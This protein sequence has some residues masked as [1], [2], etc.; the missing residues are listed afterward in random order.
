[1]IEIEGKF[2]D[3]DIKE[4]RK[5]L[6]LNNAKKIHKMMLYKRYVFFLLTGEKGYIRTRQENKLVTITMKTYPKDS[7]FAK[8]TEIS[9]N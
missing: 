7:K 8:E 6:K 5:N 4:L 2:L 9:V 1:M 3:V